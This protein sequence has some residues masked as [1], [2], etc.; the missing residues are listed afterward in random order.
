LLFD[1]DPALPRAPRQHQWQVGGRVVK[2]N[3]ARWLRGCFHFFLPAASCSFAP[4]YRFLAGGGRAGGLVAARLAGVLG[5]AAFCCGSGGSRPRSAANWR[6]LWS[7]R[8]P[9]GGGSGGGAPG[10]AGLRM[11]AQR[12]CLESAGASRRAACSITTSITS[13]VNRNAPHSSV[14]LW[15]L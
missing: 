5:G 7:A 3:D 9:A 4:L 2:D 13:Q 8:P 6:A 15:N 1:G 14:K 12:C 11:A 10:A